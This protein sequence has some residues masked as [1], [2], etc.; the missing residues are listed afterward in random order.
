MTAAVRL[1]YGPPDSVWV[2]GAEM[3]ELESLSGLDPSDVEALP[4]GYK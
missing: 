2:V 4:A 3:D 1:L